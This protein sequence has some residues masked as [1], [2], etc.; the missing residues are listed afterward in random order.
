[1]C[2]LC[3][4]WLVDCVAC[5]CCDWLIVL[6]V[7]V[8]IGW[9]CC[10]S[11][12]VGQSNYFSFGY[13]KP[14][15]LPQSIAHRSWKLILCTVFFA[16]PHWLT[17]TVCP[18][19]GLPRCLS[20]RHWLL[21]WSQVLLLVNILTYICYSGLIYLRCVLLRLQCIKSPFSKS[22]SQ[23]LLST[24]QVSII[25]RK[26]GGVR[27]RCGIWIFCLFLVKFPTLGTGKKFIFDKIS[28]PG[29]NKTV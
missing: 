10:L 4:L 2:C 13:L 29:D 20:L 18:T 16:V 26:G 17:S 5:V 14:A 12:V 19:S 6:L 7:S 9:L 21:D 8:V 25:R 11:I 28:T 3:L 27:Q 22:K 15:L 23:F 24:I 1:L